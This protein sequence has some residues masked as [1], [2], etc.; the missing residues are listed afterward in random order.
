[1]PI[2]DIKGLRAA[3]E[4]YLRDKDVFK[5]HKTIAPATR[6][7][8][9][10]EDLELYLD[11]GW[12]DTITVFNVPEGLKDTDILEEIYNRHGIM[13]SGCFGFK[14]LSSHLNIPF[15]KV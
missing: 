8:L 9:N 2:S 11:N 15:S 10:A 1:M 7:A 5:R 13:I 12:A 14:S 4:N 6:K 3:L